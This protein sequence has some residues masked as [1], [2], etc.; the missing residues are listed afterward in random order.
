MIPI[1]KLVDNEENIYEMTCAAI[2]RASQI[3]VTGDDDFMHGT[4]HGKGLLEMRQRDLDG[5]AVV[6][7]HAG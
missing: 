2:K 3:T 6:L 1:D 4:S 5:G 7:V